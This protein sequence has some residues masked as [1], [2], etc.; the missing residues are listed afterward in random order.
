MGAPDQAEE[1][2]WVTTP[3]IPVN[4]RAETL[5]NGGPENTACPVGTLQVVV[6]LFRR[7]HRPAVVA[8][9]S[10]IMA[11]GSTVGYTLCW[12]RSVTRG[13]NNLP[14]TAGEGEVIIAGVG[15]PNTS[16]RTW[17]GWRLWRQQKKKKAVH[18]LWSDTWLSYE[19]RTPEITS[20]VTFSQD[21]TCDSQPIYF[22]TWGQSLL[23]PQ[24]SFT[25]RAPYTVFPGG[26]RS[27][28]WLL[29]PWRMHAVALHQWKWDGLVHRLSPL[30]SGDW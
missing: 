9:S 20:A 15:P 10:T 13:T 7:Q 12:Q 26:S 30:L 16:T 5:W 27:A 11:G 28:H 24:T 17:E 8:S 1:P 23:T 29:R 2:G 3:V 19:I 14:L 21:C 18:I 6:A 22:S 25:W 4:G